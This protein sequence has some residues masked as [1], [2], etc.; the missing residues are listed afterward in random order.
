VHADAKV[1]LPRDEA[2]ALHPSPRDTSSNNLPGFTQI[3]DYR[4]KVRRA[5]SFCAV[6]FPYLTYVTCRLCYRKTAPSSDNST[7]TP[8]SNA[9]SAYGALNLVSNLVRASEREFPRS[10]RPHLPATAPKSVFALRGPRSLSI[11]TS[12]DLLDLE[13]CHQTLSK[14]ELICISSIFMLNLIPCSAEQ[15]PV[16]RLHQSVP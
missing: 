2:R 11:L 5:G 8:Q 13:S 1:A 9:N 4:A 14:M 15:P 7:P 10:S 6:C 16:R 12:L 3:W